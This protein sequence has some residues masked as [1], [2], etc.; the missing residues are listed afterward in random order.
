MKGLVL[1][2]EMVAAAAVVVAVV[3]VVA[4]VAVAVVAAVAVVGGVSGKN[5][6]LVV[7]IVGCFVWGGNGGEDI[8]ESDGMVG[9]TRGRWGRY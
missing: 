4:A 8:E 2:A 7:V 9:G 3:A 1:C 6:S 5:S